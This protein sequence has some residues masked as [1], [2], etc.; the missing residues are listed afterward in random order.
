MFPSLATPENMTRNNVSGQFSHPR[1]HDP[2]HM[3]PSLATPENM[4]RN[5]CF[6]V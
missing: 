4:T 3:F 2:Q 1:K 5:I 6:P